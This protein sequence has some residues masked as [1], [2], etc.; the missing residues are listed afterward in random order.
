MKRYFTPKEATQTLPL[1]KR[2][3]S[4]IQETGQSLTERIRELG[5]D[6]SAD[7]EVKR[8][9]DELDDLLQELQ[10]L[11]CTYKDPSF[12]KGL[13]DFPAMIDGEEVLLCWR[14]DEPAIAYYHSLEAGYPGRKPIP[15][16]YLKCAGS[17]QDVETPPFR[18]TSRSRP[19]M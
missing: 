1:V 11:G 18:S 7:P 17:E 4:D 16:A 19:G 10:D 14:S 9:A 13:V 12:S 3:V 5:A 15:E 2:I 6:A 8:L